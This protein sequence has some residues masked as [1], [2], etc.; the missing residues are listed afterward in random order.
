M[1]F[2]NSNKAFVKQFDKIDITFRISFLTIFQL[3]GD[4]SRKYLRIMFM[5]LGFGTERPTYKN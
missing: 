5:N 1:R 3:K 4:W 2:I